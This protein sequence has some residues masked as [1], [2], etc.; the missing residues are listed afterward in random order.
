MAL[1][2]RTLL[3]LG[4][5]I[6]AIS[7]AA[8]LV[9]AAAPAPALSVAALRVAIAAALLLVIA[10]PTLGS[11]LRRLTGRE[12]V[13]LALSGLLLGA[14]FG[15]WIASLG[16]TSTAASVALVATNPVFAALFGQLLGDRVMARE[17]MGIAIAI[18]GCAILA[19]GDWS[20]GGD[21]LLGDGLALLG[22]ALAAG[23][24]V[25]GR[26][27]RAALPLLP[28]LASI[29]VVAALG[30]LAAAAV[31]G[32]P[33]LTLPAPS[34]LAIAA[35]ALVASLGGHSLLAAAARTAPTH[36]VALAILGEPIGAS[37]LTWACFGD[38]PP[39]LAGIGG[40][41]ALLGIAAGFSG[42]TR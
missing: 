32:A 30:L 13:R 39:A 5:A 11:A 4:L 17:W 35:A 9:Q 42:R 16:L 10:A 15:V 23:S 14:H 29:N 25:L 40:G 37:L 27:L 19:G 28:Y 6:L 34:Y 18:A 31:V 36:L 26:S 41:V 2:R 8:P 38:A 3:Q 12:R 33:L 21:A 7:T 1:P 20:A 22:A 24:L